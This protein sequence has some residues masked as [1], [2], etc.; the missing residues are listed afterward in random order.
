MNSFCISALVL[1]TKSTLLPASS[2]KTNS[3]SSSKPATPFNKPITSSRLMT[4]LAS[5][6]AAI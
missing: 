4:L 5:I 3:L 1:S 2:D 6:S